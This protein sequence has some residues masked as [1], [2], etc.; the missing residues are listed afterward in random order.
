MD[1]KALSLDLV[2]PADAGQ[3]D[4]VVL[5][6]SFGADVD[7]AVVAVSHGWAEGDEGGYC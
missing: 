4:D 7:T 6:V 2:N 5:H 1:L 3:V